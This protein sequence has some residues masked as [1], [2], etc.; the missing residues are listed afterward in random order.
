[1]CEIYIPLSGIDRRIAGAIVSDDAGDMFLAHRGKIG[2]GKPGAGMSHFWG[3]YRGEAL[4][5]QDGDRTTRMALVAKFGSSQFLS[6]L[7][8]FVHAVAETK[9]ML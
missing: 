8:N 5:V 7:K 3:H 2:G 6:Q 4:L 9:K 1:M